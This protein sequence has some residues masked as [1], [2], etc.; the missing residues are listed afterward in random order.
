MIVYLRR[1]RISAGAYIKLKSMKYEPFK[2]VKKISD[3]TYVVDLPSDMAMSKTFKVADL[4]DY[5]PTEKLYLDNSM[6]SSFEE[7][8]TDVKD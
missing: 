8:E 3:N 1:E 7:E 6:M 2:I 5:H 4:Y